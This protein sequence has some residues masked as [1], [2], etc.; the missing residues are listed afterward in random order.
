MRRRGEVREIT[1][2]KMR[3]G[4]KGESQS[5]FPTMLRS[6]AIILGTLGDSGICNRDLFRIAF[7]KKLF[8][9]KLEH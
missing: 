8:S 4:S 3:E 9:C 5:A 7:Y 1:K 2:T 6:L